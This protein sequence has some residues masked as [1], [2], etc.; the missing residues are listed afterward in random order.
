[1]PLHPAPTRRPPGV[2][3]ALALATVTLAACAPDGLVGPDGRRDA[4]TAYVGPDP[5]VFVHGWNSNGTIW[6]TMIDRFKTDGYTDA[7][8]HAFSYDFSRSNATTAGII[9]RKVDSIRTATGAPKVDV[10]THSMGGLSG[11][12]YVKNL[13]GTSTVDA[14]VSLG[15]PN[16]GTSTANVC[17]QTSCLE[18]RPNS[19]FLADLNKRDETPG[20]TVRWGTWWSPCDAVILPQSSTPLNGA[21]NRQT[22]CIAHSV[23]YQDAT[24]YAQVRDWVR[25]SGTQQ[26]LAASPFGG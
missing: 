12:Y 13:G 20:T 5:I 25:G 1:M 19:R 6:T 16:H 9:Q 17:F 24:I 7:Q 21:T 18:M 4:T 2:R 26:L 8:L 14:W 22:A 3:A 11:R 15:G 23:L 10:I